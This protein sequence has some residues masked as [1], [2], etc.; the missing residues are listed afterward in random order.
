MSS[1]L[2]L[3]RL[4][5]QIGYW[6]GK[7]FPDQNHQTI[8]AHFQEEVQELHMAVF[9][10]FDDEPTVQAEVGEEIADCIILLLA[11]AENLGIVASQEVNKKMTKNFRSDFAL[12]PSKGYHKKVQT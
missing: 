8:E 4:Q 1:M 3:W 12:D 9:M 5:K 11:L 6:C 10:P 2:D 7:V